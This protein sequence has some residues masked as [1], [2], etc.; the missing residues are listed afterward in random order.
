[1]AAAR[2][3]YSRHDGCLTPESPGKWYR[4]TPVNL[5]TLTALPDGAGVEDGETVMLS[6]KMLN[7]P[8]AAHKRM[9]EMLKITASNCRG[10]ERPL[11]YYVARGSRANRWWWSTLA[12]YGNAN[13][14]FT[15]RRQILDQ[16]GLLV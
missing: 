12:H 10:S 7:R 3:S 5:D 15:T 2:D 4:R 8:R 16:T 13:D 9:V 1:M 6:G 11:I 14:K